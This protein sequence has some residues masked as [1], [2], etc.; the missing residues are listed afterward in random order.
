MSDRLPLTDEER[1]ARA[2]LVKFAREM[3]SGELSFIEGAAAVVRLRGR[4]GGVGDFDEDFMTFVA[5]DSETDHLPLQA[6][7]P[8]W[9]KSALERLAPEFEK[10]QEWASTFALASCNNLIGRFHG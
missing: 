9:D 8:L 5:I 7:W 1:E 4:I 10:A 6:Q 2:L 3:L